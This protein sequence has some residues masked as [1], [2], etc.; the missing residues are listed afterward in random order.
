M[1]DGFNSFLVKTDIYC[2]Y[3]PGVSTVTNLVVLFQKCFVIPFIREEEIDKS[4]YFQ[5]IKD[6]DYSDCFVFL[7][8]FISNLVYFLCGPSFGESS[9][10]NHEKRLRKILLQILLQDNQ[11]LKGSQI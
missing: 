8:P 4:R 3:I 1:I 9:K 5:H 2:D 7:V 11:P 6:K 10:I